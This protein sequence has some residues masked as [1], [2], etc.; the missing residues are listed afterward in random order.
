MA[1]INTL[2]KSIVFFALCMS[3][4][5]P[6]KS[7]L[8]LQQVD[9]L[10]SKELYDLHVDRKGY[11]WIAHDLGISR[12]DGLN[13][14]HFSCPG[15]ASL[16]MSGIIE[17]NHGRIWC[18]NFSGQIF[19]IERGQ[20]KLLKAYNY[21]KEIQF[22]HI[23]I[24]GDELLATSDHGLFV[25]STTDLSSKYLSTKN[26]AYTTLTAIFKLAILVYKKNCYVYLHDKGIKKLIADSVLNSNSGNSH[27]Q[28]A[29]FGNLFYLI[30]NPSGF[31]QKILYKN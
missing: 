14:T 2:I 9:G 23:A 12:F 27:I 16:S 15:Q 29:N 25:C 30:S 11:L 26:T 13:F 5:L 17:D 24:C 8:N 4:F 18:H 1:N 19:Y 28:P 21:A 31:V 3:L 22:P 20:M 6:A 10:P 7:Q